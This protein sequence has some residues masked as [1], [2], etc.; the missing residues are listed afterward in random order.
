MSQGVLGLVAALGAV[1]LA[2]VW[3]WYTLERPRQ[4]GCGWRDVKPR[5]A[6]YLIGFVTN[7]FDALGIG[8]FAPTTAAFKLLNRMPDE[9]IPGTLNA[10][11][12]PPVLVEASVFISVVRVDLTTLVT[13]IGASV[14]GAYAPCLITV[15][16]L[17]M[18]PLAAFPIMMGACA[19]LM[20]VGGARFIREG[21]YNLPASLGLTLARG[22]SGAVRRC[23]DAVVGPSRG[24]ETET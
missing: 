6:D 13:M 8:N 4:T 5:P 21:R 2:F 10:G 22:R 15:S 1:A 12:S 24:N 23:T 14:L 11:H 18:N 7:F 19:F 17:G 16:L 20:P 9:E 3:R